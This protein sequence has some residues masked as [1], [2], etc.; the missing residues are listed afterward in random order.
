MFKLCLVLDLC[1]HRF[2][3]VL[4]EH[5]LKLELLTTIEQ[6]SQAWLSA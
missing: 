3:Y 6:S 4:Q 5:N 1:E 2:F